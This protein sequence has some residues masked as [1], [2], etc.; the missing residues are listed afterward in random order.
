LRKALRSLSLRA[1]RGNRSEDP[2]ARDT[3]L[4]LRILEET[5]GRNALKVQMLRK[6]IKLSSS[7]RSRR[8]EVGC[9]RCLALDLG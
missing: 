4:L 2:G 1:R 3:G 6:K 7:E 5:L 9:T 8:E